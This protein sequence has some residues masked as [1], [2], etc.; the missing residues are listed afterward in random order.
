[1]KHIR[2]LSI[3]AGA[4]ALVAA[5]SVPAMAQVEEQIVS[6]PKSRDQ[7]VMELEQARMDG[8]LEKTHGEQSYAPDF[9]EA[10]GEDVRYSNTQSDADVTVSADASSELRFDAPAAGGKSRAEVLEELRQAQQDG[11]LEMLWGEPSRAPEFEAARGGSS[12]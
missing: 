5:L 11:S 1:M 12:W 8:T 10:M 2:R 4:A 9:A 3:S 6:G 7:V